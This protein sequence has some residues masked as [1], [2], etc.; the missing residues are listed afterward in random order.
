MERMP[1][2]SNEPSAGC[3]EGWVGGCEPIAEA[4]RDTSS[5]HGCQ[6]DRWMS[7]ECNMGVECVSLCRLRQHLHI[8]GS[9][10]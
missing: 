7:K 4:E 3:I 2:I 8:Q 10:C 6:M 5:T 1:V 9:V